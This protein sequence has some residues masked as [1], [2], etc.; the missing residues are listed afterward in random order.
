MEQWKERFISNLCQEFPT[1]E[2]EN[3]AR[4]RQLF[5]HVK[6]ATS[7][8]PESQDSKREWATLLYRGA[9]YAWQMGNVSDAREI[10][11]KS[12]KQRVVIF[13]AESEEALDSTAILASAYKL[14]GN[15]E[16]AEQ[17]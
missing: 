4:C 6:L 13:G 14:E 12:R 3:W 17:L 8:R 9:W 2:Y 5:P 7:Q 11:S 10:A 1:G 16:G 15:W